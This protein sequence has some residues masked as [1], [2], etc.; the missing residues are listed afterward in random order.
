MVTKSAFRRLRSNRSILSPFT[1]PASAVSVFCFSFIC[2]SF[3]LPSNAAPGAPG[4]T[5]AKSPEQLSG[6]AWGVAEKI[7]RQVSDLRKADPKAAAELL[8]KTLDETTDPNV[9]ADFFTTLGDVYTNDLKAPD[10]ALALFDRAFPIFQKPE[11]KIPTYHWITMVGSKARALM[12]SK[13][14]NDV[15]ALLKENMPS[16]LD[17]AQSTAGGNYPKMATRDVMNVRFALLQAQGREKQIPDELTAFLLASPNYL[18][19]S[20]S[21]AWSELLTQL[22]KQ[23]RGEEA[24]S[25]GKLSYRLGNFKKEDIEK[26]TQLLNKL[27]ASQDDFAAVRVF[28]KAQTDPTVA[29]PLANVKVPVLP[30]AAQETINKRITD[31][32]GRQIIG[33]RMEV[34]REIVDLRLILGTPEDLREAMLSAQKM[35]RERP[36]LQDGTLQICRV[37]KAADMNLIRANA[38]LSYLEGEGKNPIPDFLK[39]TS[40]AA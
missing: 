12:A 19:D 39:E 30:A 25:W 15:E 11:Y 24:L 20:S 26:A 7:R 2:P 23:G 14:L 1:L 33:F 34:A 40:P 6:E 17:A 3:C 8:E 13:R 22:Q 4:A 28:N 9:A 32:E 21:W 38:F 37:F 27:W 36:D 35:L 29:N 10:K 16:V 31:L 18:K 5:P